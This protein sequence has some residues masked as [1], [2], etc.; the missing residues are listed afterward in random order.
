MKAI[1]IGN[2]K[3]GER[4]GCYIIA[5]I[6]MNHNGDITL[7]K[8]IIESAVRSGC[9]AVKFQLFTAEKLVI[10]SVRTYGAV[11]G[12]LPKYQYQMYKRYEL[13]EKQYAELRLFCRK[14]GIGFLGSVFD[15]ENADMLERVGTDAFKIASMDIT[16][17]DLITHVAKKGLPVII[18]TGIAEASEISD[19]IKAVRRTKNNRLILLH[20][21]S[22]YP[23]E[24][25]KSNLLAIQSLKRFG[26]IVGYSDHSPGHLGDAIAVALGARVIEKHF[27]ISKKLPGVDHHLSMSPAEMKKMV[28]SIR[29]VEKALGDGRIGPTEEEAETGNVARRSIV[30]RARIPKGAVITRDMLAIKRPG[31]GIKPKH[32]GKL[33]GK[34]ARKDVGADQLM[35]FSMVE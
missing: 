31:T 7:A 6:G 35:S 3:V 34:R 10:K 2:K 16:Y 18:S 1:S 28:D 15:T 32:I 13:S 29:V 22:S 25:E 27:T 26:H 21:I 9:D 11:K 30:S 4:T 8:R 14:K 12:H 24:T 17:L 33:I 5:E 23:S 19:A 20:C